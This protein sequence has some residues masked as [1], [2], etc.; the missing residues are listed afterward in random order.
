MANDGTVI[1]KPRYLLVPVKKGEHVNFAETVEGKNTG[2]IE[3]VV[4]DVGKNRVKVIFRMPDGGE[5]ED[6]IPKSFLR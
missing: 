6:I 1:T 5:Y 2:V 3:K 4:G